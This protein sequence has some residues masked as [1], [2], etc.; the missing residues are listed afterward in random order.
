MVLN[1]M[2]SIAVIS[3]DNYNDSSRIIDGNFD[4]PRL[5][6]YDMLLENIH[7]LKQ[8]KPVQVPIYDFKLNCRT[9]YRHD[10]NQDKQ[11]NCEEFVEFIQKLT[12]ETLTVVSRNMI[13]AVVVATMIALMTK[14]AC[15]VL[16]GWATGGRRRGLADGHGREREGG[17]RT[18][19]IRALADGIKAWRRVVE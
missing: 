16:S 2:P 4:D 11:L 6:D 7:G 1:F 3:M 13:V 10:T 19:G 12:A 18:I 14:R 5:T 9:G 8:G 15:P 17:G